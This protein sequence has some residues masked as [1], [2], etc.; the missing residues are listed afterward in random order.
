MAAVLAGA[1]A[2]PAPAQDTAPAGGALQPLARQ[3]AGVAPVA[4]PET[5]PQTS[6]TAPTD[7]QPATAGGLQTGARTAAPAAARPSSPGF[8]FLSEER[9]LTD[10]RRGQALLAAEE[11][12][13]DALRAEARAIEMA[14]E[15]EERRL[16]DQR[17]TMDATEFRALADDFDARV[18]EAR[19][20]QDEKATALAQRFD[21][22]RR[23]F[24]VDVAPV[25]VRVMQRAGALAIFDD[26][27]VLLS[28]QALD[29]TDEVIAELDAAA[30]EPQTA[31]GTPAPPAPQPT[32]APADAPSEPATPAPGSE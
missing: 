8:L 1:L 3:P 20:E 30:P 25:L 7:A 15:E 28:D 2:A 6:T 31:P 16:T 26:G 9:L 14:F 10:S 24:Y 27:S 12:G 5:A 13:R 19:R 11:A 29:V 4:R 17:A 23:Q 18:V 21:Q 32:G 22:D